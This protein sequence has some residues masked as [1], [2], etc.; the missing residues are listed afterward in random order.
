MYYV[1]VTDAFGC[2]GNDSS[3]VAGSVSTNNIELVNNLKVYPN[4]SNGL[5]KISGSIQTEGE[6]TFKILNVL[7]Q[8]VYFE[9]ENQKSELVKII[10]L[11]AYNKGVYFV[12][13]EKR[14]GKSQISKVLL[15]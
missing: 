2:K 7:G 9:S 11:S 15:Q 13:V 5:I 6:Y 10:D 8:V 3:L 4:P 14:G 12:V 1:T